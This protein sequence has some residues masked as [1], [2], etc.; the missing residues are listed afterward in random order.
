[1]PTVAELATRKVASRPFDKRQRRR[2]A[3]KAAKAEEQRRVQVAAEAVAADF[4]QSLQVASQEGIP[5]LFVAF[6]SPCVTPRYHDDLWTTAAGV[7]GGGG[8][9]WRCDGGG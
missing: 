2:A 5:S 1:M 6:T 8:A 3:A 4:A 9:G 7:S